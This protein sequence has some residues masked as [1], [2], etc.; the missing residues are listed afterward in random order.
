MSLAIITSVVSLY[1]YIFE[2]RHQTT[3]TTG[4][5][6]VFK[7]ET[8]KGKKI[9]FGNPFDNFPVYAGA[10]AGKTKSIGKPLLEQYI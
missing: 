8:I 3:S 9:E 1:G 5:M 4:Q 7:L 2:S 6:P 10:N